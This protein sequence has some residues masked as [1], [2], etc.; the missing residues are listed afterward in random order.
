MVKLMVANL[1]VETIILFIAA[2]APV[3]CMS[4]M[5]ALH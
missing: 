3:T 4:S 2:N 1:V 5:Y